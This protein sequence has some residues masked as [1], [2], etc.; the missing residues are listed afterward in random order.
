M[1]YTSILLC[2]SLCIHIT[3]VAQEENKKI[4]CDASCVNELLPFLFCDMSTGNKVTK[5]TANP[6]NEPGLRALKKRM[7]PSCHNYDEASF[8]VLPPNVSL[9][10]GETVIFDPSWIKAASFSAAI[11]WW[12]ES[13]CPSPQTDGT[14]DCCLNVRW[15]QTNEDL[16]DFATNPAGVLA[17]NYNKL[18]PTSGNPTCR[19]DCNETGVILNGTPQFT[20]PNANNIPT[21]FFYNNAEP[22]GNGKLDDGNPLEYYHINSV[23]THEVGHWYGIGHMGENDSY[24]QQCGNTRGNSMMSG[25]TGGGGLYPGEERTLKDDDLCAFRKLYCCA[26]TSTDIEETNAV[27]AE[28]FVVYPNPLT[29]SLF[30]IDMGTQLLPYTKTLR[31]VDER[32]K[33]VQ[34]HTLSIGTTRYTVDATGLPN[35]VYMVVITAQQLHGSISAKIVVGR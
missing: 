20:Q 9:V 13:G 35:G 31:L 21:R 24:G 23:I 27:I 8:T 1:R 18:T 2:F 32:G 4:D 5:C 34:E 29:S 28:G 11:E 33:T 15:A 3:A 22:S 10:Q 16:I 6:N 7:P 30:V 26:Q 12:L 19:V 25:G 14:D 17:V